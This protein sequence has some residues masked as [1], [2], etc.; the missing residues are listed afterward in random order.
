MFDTALTTTAGKGQIDLGRELADLTVV[1]RS[2]DPSLLSLEILVV[3]D[4]P[5]TDLSY[6]LKKEEALLGLAGAVLGTVLLGPFGILIPL[7]STCTG[8]KNPCRTA[9]EQP[10]ESPRHADEA[11]AT[12]PANAVEELLDNVLGIFD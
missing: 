6:N 4:G 7:V 3:I 8:D 2:K 11:P 10:V 1:P 12:G 9:L 5:L